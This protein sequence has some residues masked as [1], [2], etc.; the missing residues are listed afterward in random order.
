[1]IVSKRFVDMASVYMASVTSK[2][3]PAEQADKS[4][5]TLY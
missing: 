2:V 4:L 3:L 5:L 1:M